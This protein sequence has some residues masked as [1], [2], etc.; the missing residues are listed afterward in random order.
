MSSEPTGTGPNTGMQKVLSEALGLI[1]YDGKEYLWRGYFLDASVHLGTALYQDRTLEPLHW[2]ARNISQDIWN[3]CT[4][5][6]RLEWFSGQ[7]IANDS[8]QSSVLWSLSAGLDIELFNIELRSILDYAARILGDMANQKGTVPDKSFADLY[9]WLQKNPRMNTYSLGEEATTL[10][11]SA[12]WY[13]ELRAIRTAIIHHGAH[14]LVFGPKPGIHFLLVDEFKPL[15]NW[16]PLMWNENLV[17]FE[18]YAGL[19][20]AR[21]LVFLEGLGQL[22]VARIPNQLT[23]PQARA[24]FIGLGILKQW[25]SR[26]L[27]KLRG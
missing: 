5:A 4:L 19:Y 25:I 15:M 18:L 6:A 11:L 10:V 8:F 13:S 22:L 14:V 7:V 1:D 21:T 3:V 9:G 16:G 12:S 17:D 23:E 26:I 20:F 2:A 27:N 24:N